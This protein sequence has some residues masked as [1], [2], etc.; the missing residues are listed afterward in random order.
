MQPIWLTVRRIPLS[1]LM[2]PFFSRTCMSKVHPTHTRALRSDLK[3]MGLYCGSIPVGLTHTG[4]FAVESLI[5]A[6]ALIIGI[7]AVVW[8]FD[9]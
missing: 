1:I 3:R 7:A 5:I 6:A 4:A 2:I 8:M 9:C